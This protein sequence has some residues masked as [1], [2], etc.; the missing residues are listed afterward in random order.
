MKQPARMSGVTNGDPACDVVRHT[1]ATLAYRA[2]KAVRGAPA[3]YG[4]FRV[5]ATTRTPAQILAH[6]CDL[7]D[8]ALTMA[9]GQAQWRNSVPQSW[10]E[11]VDRLF[12][13]VTALDHYLASG[14]S[15]ANRAL[16][17]LFQGPIADALAHTGQL[18][19]LRRLADAPVRGEAYQAA[20]I[21]AGQTGLSQPPPAFEFD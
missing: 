16:L 21:V 8:W 15:V 17:Q 12:T 7:M 9:Q 19:L 6:M 20:A 13:A 14:A 1:L 18:T 2:S 3:S 10:P 4:D 5:G 11:D